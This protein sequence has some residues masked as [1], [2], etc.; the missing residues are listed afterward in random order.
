MALMPTGSEDGIGELWRRY[1]RLCEAVLHAEG[2][3]AQLELPRTRSP[4]QRELVVVLEQAKAIA[5]SLADVLE[6]LDAERGHARDGRSRGS[7]DEIYAFFAEDHAPREDAGHEVARTRLPWARNGVLERLHRF[8]FFHVDL[9]NHLYRQRIPATFAWRQ[10]MEL[11][12][13]FVYFGGI[14]AEGGLVSRLSSLAWRPKLLKQAAERARESEQLLCG[15]ITSFRREQ[16]FGVITLD[17]GRAVK[18]DA[19][20][21]TM[22]PS[23]GDAVRLRVGPATQGGGLKA[24]HVEPPSQPAPPPSRAIDWT[25]WD[26]E[27]IR[28]LR[29][30]GE[31][32]GWLATA[33]DD[34]LL[35]RHRRH[36]CQEI[37][38][39]LELTR[40]ER[41]SVV[42][43]LL[44]AEAPVPDRA[45]DDRLITLADLEEL[46]EEV[47]QSARSKIGGSR[48]G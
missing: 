48:S 2:V 19:A 44:L 36:W 7:V 28:A 20:N 40:R 23:Q 45:V 30:M 8:Y 11:W 18:F 27:D 21:C 10:N 14:T 24:L 1:D 35:E 33:D 15:Q 5:I 13:T 42:L 41:S 47:R 39:Q 4:E 17:D 43:S 25:P 32:A 37:D 38:H 9:N 16:G 26:D 3:F 12:Q 46:P 22:V 29:R 6:R 34:A 31:H